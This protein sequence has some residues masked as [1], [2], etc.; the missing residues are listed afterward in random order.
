[1]PLTLVLG[2]ANSAKAGEIFGAYGA[3]AARGALLVVPNTRD[4]EHYLRELAEDGAVV[5][6]VITFSGLAHEIARRVGYRPRL[7]SA[8]QRDRV[9]ARAVRRAQLELLAPAAQ[10]RGFAVAAVALIAELERSLVTPQR[11]TQAMSA[12][13][14]QDPRRAQYAREVA[15][16]YDAYA[17]ELE[18]LERV[19]AEL[20]TWRALDALR[21]EPAR[22]GRDA[23]FFYGFDDLHPLERDAVETLAGVVGA[24][25]TVSLP[26]EA[27]RQA[28]HARAEVV[29]E[30][31][32][33]AERVID[34]PAAG[35]L[36]RGRV[37]GCPSP[38]GARAV[39][40]SPGRARRGG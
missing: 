10:S 36:L 8:L 2:P 27:G 25:V 20:F 32:P 18:R 1:M 7:V 34:L 15:R 4:A 26:Y 31:R 28:F 30:L 3:A 11:F 12:W 35:R 13:G 22:W 5:G 29:Q 14:S 16:L 19:D 9:L 40:P 33:L 21:R 23:V 38:S 37:P 39:R 6:S 24:E 17:R